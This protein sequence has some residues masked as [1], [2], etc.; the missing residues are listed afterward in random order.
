MLLREMTSI[1]TFGRNAQLVNIVEAWNFWYVTVYILLT[2][3]AFPLL[4]ESCSKYLERIL[5]HS[6]MKRRFHSSVKISPSLSLSQ[7]Y[8]IDPNKN[9]EQK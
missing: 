1:T 3:A 8:A 9:V 5:S 6:K 2:V 7:S 4:I